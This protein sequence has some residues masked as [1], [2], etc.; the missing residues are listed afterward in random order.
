MNSAFDTRNPALFEVP[1]PPQEFGQDGGKFY[2]YYDAFAEEI[3]DNMVSGLKEQLEGLLIFAGLFAGVNSAFLALTLPLMSPD[4]ADDTNAIL[5][6]NNAILLNLALGRNDTLPSPSPLPSE[7]FSPTGKVLTV[8]VLFS[9]SLTFAIIS[10]FLAVLGRQ[11]LVYYRKR[12]GGGPER[13]RWEQLKRF[14]GAER[15]Q[16]EWVL[17]DFLPSLLQIGLIIFCISLTIYLN[18]LHPTLSNVVGALMCVGLAI[19]IITAIFAT[20]DKF[21]PFQSPLSHAVSAVFPFLLCVA[22]L[23]A[24]IMSMLIY[25]LIQLIG[26]GLQFLVGIARALGDFCLHGP[27]NVEPPWKDIEMESSAKEMLS[28]LSEKSF[29]SLVDETLE[30][31][32]VKG[33]E[34]DGKLQ[35]TAIRRAI[36]TS[37]DAWTQVHA[38]S[39]ILGITNTHLLQQ[40]AT[41]YEFF[42]RISDLCRGSYNRTLQLCGRNREDLAAATCWL[43]RAIV[44]HINLSTA[45]SIR[46]R[47]TYDQWLSIPYLN[48]RALQLS[49]SLGF[50]HNAAPNTVATWLGYMA[51][52]DDEY[53]SEARQLALDFVIDGVVNPSWRC[54]SMVIAVVMMEWNVADRTHEELHAAYTRWA[55]YTRGRRN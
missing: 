44:T 31:V 55:L 14:L 48:D 32:G 52:S 10:S 50:I 38:A 8:N 17:D 30:L 20:W 7:T 28:D 34:D 46:K 2:H 11:W 21:C 4:P 6:D 53:P 16:L 27:N 19:L 13:Q 43:Y 22:Y 45:S 33:E 49:I 9:V 23:S 12:T 42:S 3:D 39:N 35:I 15:W 37:D 51:D 18:T 29:K 26:C 40:L 24:A 1:V 25:D 41:D 36:C 54:V 47:F 5:R